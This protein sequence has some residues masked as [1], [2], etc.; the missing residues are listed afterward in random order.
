VVFAGPRLKADDVIA[1][2]VA[3][4]RKHA[5]VVTADNE[6]MS[7][8]RNAMNT[9]ERAGYEVQFLHPSK[10][11]QDFEAITRFQ[12]DL[13]S[14]NTLSI[15]T[16]SDN[17]HNN[18]PM[19]N[20]TDR[21]IEAIDE[22]IQIRGGL[23]ET[24]T[25]MKKKSYKNSPKERR[26]LE[27]RA[28]MLCER[29]AQKS[30]GGQ[31]IDRLTTVDGII[32]DYERE[33]QNAV[34]EQWVALRRTA[35]RKE[36]TGDR[37]MLA[38]HFRRTMEKQI[39]LQD[40]RNITD[41]ILLEGH[42]LGRSDDSKKDE[43]QN[44]PALQHVHHVNSLMG[45]NSSKSHTSTTSISTRMATTNSEIT[46]ST[47]SEDIETTKTQ[48]NVLRMV[49]ISDTHGFEESLTPNATLLPDGDVLLH[50]GDFSVDGS[51]RKKKEALR[52]FDEW[53]SMQKHRLK[54][55]LRGNHDPFS[56]SF[57]QVCY[58]MLSMYLYICVLFL[59]PILFF[60]PTPYTM[61]GPKV[62]QLMESLYLQ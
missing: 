56:V 43:Q 9:I 23:Y 20:I 8:C 17:I 55:V 40:E 19:I 61:L 47:I 28:R 27:K 25:I 16:Q 10:I 50:L 11:I 33:F 57:T 32:T 38:E 45:I 14:N 49:V 3:A 18:S 6:L 35:T 54:V 59:K 36:M 5:L 1:R 2:D 30:G 44:N 12:D 39:L 34:L 22:E 58:L 41:L 21:L 7:R 53:L 29:L 46:Y 13:S 4:L 37:I 26:K 52:K 31:S 24:E 15:S 62:L 51:I 42:T 60:S 48:T